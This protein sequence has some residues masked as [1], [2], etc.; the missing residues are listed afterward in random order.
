[1][2]IPV[3]KENADKITQMENAD[4]KE[5]RIWNK[6]HELYI[7]ILR[8]RDHIEYSFHSSIQDQHY[9]GKHS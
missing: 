2:Q 6:I 3:S 8:D 1:M 5:G 9:N 4:K 7:T